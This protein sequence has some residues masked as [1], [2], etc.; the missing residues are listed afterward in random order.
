MVNKFK[1]KCPLCGRDC[2]PFD[3]DFDYP[4]EIGGDIEMLY[5]FECENCCE[6]WAVEVTYGV[7][8]GK[9]TYSK[10][11]EIEEP[12]HFVEDNAE[13]EEMSEAKDNIKVNVSLGLDEKSKKAVE[14][15]VDEVFEKIANNVKNTG[16]IFGTLIDTW[17]NLETTLKPASVKDVFTTNFKLP[18]TKTEDLINRFFTT[19]EKKDVETDDYWAKPHKSTGHVNRG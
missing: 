13:T 9:Q 6:P 12:L 2:E 19:S 8:T 7:K 17:P 11:V 15:A 1:C 3:C 18:S 4:V 14:D 5:L 10:R 16:N